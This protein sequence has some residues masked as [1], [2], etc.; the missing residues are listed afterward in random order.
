MKTNTQET[1]MTT[2]M[3]TDNT[4]NGYIAIYQGRRTEIRGAGL[5]L[6]AAKQQAITELR[7]PKRKAHLVAIMLA[8]RDGEEVIHTADF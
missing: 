7:V 6:Y 5:T 3:K 8:E 1:K 4:I 2:D